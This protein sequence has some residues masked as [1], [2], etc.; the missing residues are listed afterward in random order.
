MCAL[1]AVTFCL[2]IFRLFGNALVTSK[3]PNM[4]TNAF[5]L[6]TGVPISFRSGASLGML[7]IEIVPY[8]SSKTILA[9]YHK[10]RLFSY[11][12]HFVPIG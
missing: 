10:P 8:Q 1:D 6:Y 5:H 7:C 9:H 11:R 12:F 2:C 4:G 3:P